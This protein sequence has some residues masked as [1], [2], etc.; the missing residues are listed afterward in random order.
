MNSLCEEVENMLEVAKDADV[1][2]PKDS[3]SNCGNTR[4]TRISR[5][6]RQSSIER[7]LI[8]K[9]AKRLADEEAL[10]KFMQL[11]EKQ[12]ELDAEEAQSKSLQIQRRFQHQQKQRKIELEKRKI[13]L[14]H[15]GR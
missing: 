4:L 6:S 12:A 8:E 11:E 15:K 13:K 9:R 7:R 14:E 1:I 10:Q 2:Q 5:S 3:I